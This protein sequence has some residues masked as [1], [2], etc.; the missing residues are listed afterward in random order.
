MFIFL[1]FHGV[2]PDKVLHY[3]VHSDKFKCLDGKKFISFSAINDNYCDCDDGSDEP[4]TSACPNGRC[5][6][7]SLLIQINLAYMYSKQTLHGTHKFSSNFPFKKDLAIILIK[8]TGV[9]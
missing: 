5:V 2:S 3:N 6:H 9:I 7:Q 8:S 1:V 4:G